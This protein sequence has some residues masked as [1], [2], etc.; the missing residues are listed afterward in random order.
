MLIRWFA[1]VA[2]W[3]RSILIGVLIG[4]AILG[5][6]LRISS[7]GLRSALFAGTMVVIAMLFLH[8]LLAHSRYHP[9]ILH[10]RPRTPAFVTPTDPSRVSL[11]AASTILVVVQ[12]SEG[13][14]AALSRERPTVDAAVIGGFLLLTAALLWHGTRRQPGVRILPGGVF[15]QQPF[16][17]LFVP[18][19]AFA[20]DFPVSPTRSNQLA[21]YFQR[22]GLIRRRGLHSSPNTLSTTTDAT[23]VARVID[24]YVAHPERRSGIGTEAELRRLTTQPFTA[25]TRDRF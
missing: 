19:D 2:R 13:F 14:G 23:F 18:W 9:A 21:L 5:A 17:S 4:S 10:A 25:K 1:A 20:R 12:V 3:Q 24:E 11:A 15:D 22:P 16:G 6:A 8:S 7:Q